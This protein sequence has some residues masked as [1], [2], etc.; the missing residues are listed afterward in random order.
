MSRRFFRA[1]GFDENAKRLFTVNL[2]G[3]QAW[4][5]KTGKIVARVPTKLPPGNPSAR[6][7]DGRWLTFDGNLLTQVL[8]T[9]TLRLT[10]ITLKRAQRRPGTGDYS[11]SSWGSWSFAGDRPTLYGAD[12]L[13]GLLG[14]WSLPGGESLQEVRV[15]GLVFAKVSRN[16]T[17]ILCSYRE[18]EDRVL[19]VLDAKT[20]RVIATRVPLR[21]ARRRFRRMVGM[22]LRSPELMLDCGI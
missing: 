15:P 16:A 8:D 5:V 14:G 2:Q 17:R 22:S 9:R 12:Q 10:D 13:N 6:S 1:N 18:P 11:M 7:G 3:I 19:R 4:D 20:L 21:S